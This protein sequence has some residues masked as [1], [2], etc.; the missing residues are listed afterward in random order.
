MSKKNKKIEV[1][2]PA[3]IEEG[4]EINKKNIESIVEDIKNNVDDWSYEV[5]APINLGDGW[6]FELEHREG[7][8]EGDGDTHWVVFS[9]CKEG[10]SPKRYFRIDGYYASYDGAYLDGTPYEVET[11]ERVV[12]V[13]ESKK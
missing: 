13:W 6:I 5:H 7:G 8:G 4:W 3:L 9:F 10:V 2:E 12:T 11:K 1:W